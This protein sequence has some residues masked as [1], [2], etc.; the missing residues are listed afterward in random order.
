M[1][2]LTARITEIQ[3][4]HRR[5]FSDRCACGDEVGEDRHAAHV[6]ALIAQAAEEH[7]RPRIE[8][9]VQLDELPDGAIYVSDSDQNTPEVR[10]DGAWYA[11]TSDAFEPDTPGTVVWSPGAGE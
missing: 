8:L 5:M 10:W 2:D 9:P 4:K 6:S 3:L 11:M 7:Y 1:S